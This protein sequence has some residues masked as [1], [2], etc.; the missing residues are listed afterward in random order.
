MLSDTDPGA[1]LCDVRAAD[2]LDFA[3]I[4]TDPQNE[5]IR[6]IMA[7]VS[8]DM[9]GLI[10]LKGVLPN[11]FKRFEGCDPKAALERCG[12]FPQPGHNGVLTFYLN[13][14]T[15]GRPMLDPNCSSRKRTLHL[16]AD[17]LQDAYERASSTW[18][19]SPPR[20]SSNS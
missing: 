6:E 5:C 19:P 1:E 12:L 10:R 9:I 11:I 7:F 8:G 18:S 15:E 16:S 3:F 4:S 14:N 13:V 17:Q 2:P 20:S